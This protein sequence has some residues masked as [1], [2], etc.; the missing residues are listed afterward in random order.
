MR[1]KREPS[2]PVYMGNPMKVT[3]EGRNDRCF[4]SPSS[5]K[6]GLS[7]HVIGNAAVATKQSSP[8]NVGGKG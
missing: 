3:I 4:P 6:G 8:K 7:T 1:S 2:S 5:S